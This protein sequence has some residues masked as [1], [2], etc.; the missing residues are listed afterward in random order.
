MSITFGYSPCPNDTFSFHAVSFGLVPVPDEV[1]VFLADVEELN[2]RALRAEF[3]LTKLSFPALFKCLDRYALLSAGS[4]LGRGVGPLL[5]TRQGTEFEPGRHTVAV[6]G[7]LTTAYLLLCLYLGR[8]PRVR[9]MEFSQVMDAVERGQA[10]AGLLIHEGR[11][12]YQ[13]RGLALVRDLGSFWE[14]VSG[15]PI[16]LGC[17]AARRDLGRENV[18]AWQEA[19]AESVAHAFANPDAPA[20]Y[21]AAHAQEME[22]GVQQSHIGL[23]VNDFSRDLGPEGLAAVEEL[24]CRGAE[25]GIH[26][27]AD[28]G[29]LIG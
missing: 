20:E 5:V 18:I 13:D 24:Y 10:D 7:M 15:Q 14:E 9:V 6:P 8:E 22:P 1:K 17:I 29:L 16:P 21:V 4:A 12:T 3:E 23:Y 26:R 25:L 11:F 28:S 19:L 27:F 2:Q